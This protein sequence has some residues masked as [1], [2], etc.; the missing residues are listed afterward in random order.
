M[1]ESLARSLLSRLARGDKGALGPFFDLH[2]GLVTG[3]ALRILRDLADAEDVVQ[4]VFLQA[5]RQADRYDPERGTPEAWLVTMTRTRALDRLRRRAARREESESALPIGTLLPK[6]ETAFSVREALETLSADQRR[7]IELAYYGG[8][9]QS[10]IAAALGE[11]LGT[12]K[13]RM[14]TGMIRLRELLGPA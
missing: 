13:T 1:T 14:R 3:M 4:E 6:D 9:T 5:W 2:A 8:L 12:I 7:A 10:E 11:P